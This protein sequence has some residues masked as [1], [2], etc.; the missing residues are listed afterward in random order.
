MTNNNDVN[1]YLEYIK[2]TINYQKEEIAADLFEDYLN[3][4]KNIMKDQQLLEVRRLIIDKFKMQNID[5][6]EGK[7]YMAKDRNFML[8]GANGKLMVVDYI[9]VPDGQKS[10]TFPPQWMLFKDDHLLLFI[11]DNKIMMISPRDMIHHVEHLY[12][13][14][15]YL[16]DPKALSELF[17]LT[18]AEMNMIKNYLS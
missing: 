7:M 4:V 2:N 8:R 17:T 14:D 9:L 15:K 5:A 18:D 11:V 6:F 16:L 3:K 1:A 12:A 13:E 10:Y